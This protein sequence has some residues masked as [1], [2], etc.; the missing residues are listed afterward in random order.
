MNVLESEIEEMI[1]DLWD[2]DA[3]FTLSERGIGI[4][5]GHLLRQFKLPNVGVIDLMHIDVSEAL[6]GRIV[7]FTVLELKRGK[8]GYTE[9]GQLARYTRHIKMGLAAVR[10]SERTKF[11][12]RGL[13]VGSEL[14]ENGDFVY[15]MS[16]MPDI[17][18]YEFK[19]D[20]VDGLTFDYCEKTWYNSGFNQNEA[21][22]ILLDYAKKAMRYG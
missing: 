21:S 11:R 17:E 8:I 12:V 18:V 19:L 9:L 15:V 3:G 4:E 7:T 5:D 20:S 1:I 13:L 22:R 6:T 2:Y 14:E 10:S 16:S